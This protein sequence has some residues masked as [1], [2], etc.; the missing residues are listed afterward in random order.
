MPTIPADQCPHGAEANFGGRTSQSATIRCSQACPYHSK[1]LLQLSSLTSE[2]IA[3]VLH[4]RKSG[5]SGV[6]TSL[7]RQLLSCREDSSSCVLGAEP[8]LEVCLDGVVSQVEVPVEHELPVAGGQVLAVP[9]PPPCSHLSP[10]KHLVKQATTRPLS[11]LMMLC[12]DLFPAS[13]SNPLLH[14]SAVPPLSLAH[15]DLMFSACPDGGGHTFVPLSRI[16][17]C[18]LFASRLS[19]MITASELE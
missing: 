4:E 19:L 14:L 12:L 8:H 7:Q 6:G 1:L 18:H 16:G 9:Q 3:L 15:W 17:I 2:H 13:S 10:Q 5:K 11:C